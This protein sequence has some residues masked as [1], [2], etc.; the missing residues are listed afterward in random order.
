ME[1]VKRC[2]GVAPVQEKSVIPSRGRF[3]PQ[4]QYSGNDAGHCGLSIPNVLDLH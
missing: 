3:R 4:T 2:A 1:V